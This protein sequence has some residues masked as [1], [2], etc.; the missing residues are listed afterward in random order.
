MN[1]KLETGIG[2]N[3]HAVASKAKEI[4]KQK[5][6][7]VEFDFNGCR[8]LV[9][10]NTNLEYLYRDYTNHSTFGWKVIGSKCV[11]EY[12]KELKTKLEKREEQREFERNEYKKKEDA[13]R[14]AFSEKTKGVL[15]EF[16]NKEYWDIGKSKNNDGYGACIYEYAEG[17]AKLM[18]VEISKGNK[19]NDIA[20]K[21]SFEMGFLGITGFMYGASVQI[22][23]KCWK[24]GD[25]LRKWHNKEYGYE[26]DGVVNP[27]VLTLNT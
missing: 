18:Q 2:D 17:W 21:T 20:A 9:D 11:S 6:L 19:L 10:S 27:A 14:F 24:Y 1:V 25:E 16:S 5:K 13:E 7:I 8:C 12:L 26:G 3:F 4:A 23:S 15:V 22:L